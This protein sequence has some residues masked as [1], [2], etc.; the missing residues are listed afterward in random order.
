MM[1]R[2]YVCS[3]TYRLGTYHTSKL[4]GQGSTGSWQTA[5]IEVSETCSCLTTLLAPDVDMDTSV[6][7]ASMFLHAVAGGSDP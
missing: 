1:C 5:R 4:G 6:A 7:D 3:R 2:W